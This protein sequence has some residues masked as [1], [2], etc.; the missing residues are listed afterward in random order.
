[1][2]TPGSRRRLTIERLNGPRTGR[3]YLMARLPIRG[4]T[5]RFYTV[6]ARLFA[7]YDDQLPGEAIVIHRVDTTRSG[8]TAQV[9]DSDNNRNPNDA[10]AMW[11]PGETFTDPANGITVAIEAE[12]TNGF[13]VTISLAA[14]GGAPG[15]RVGGVAGTVARR[16]DSRRRFPRRVSV[17]GAE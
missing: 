7:G 16:V 1:V 14:T 12:N 5:R 9:V 4:S 17:H 6:E 15:E 13:A 3:N 11:R 2:A 8:R 10:G